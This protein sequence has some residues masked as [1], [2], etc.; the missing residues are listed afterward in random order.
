MWDWDLWLSTAENS[1]KNSNLRIFPNPSN[2][3]FNINITDNSSGIIDIY[4]LT[5]KK[6]DSFEVISNESNIIWNPKNNP[7]GTYIICFR[8]KNSFGIERV[9]VNK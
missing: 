1:T 9:V 4:T 7:A 6:I 5:G 2:D 3:V 8:G